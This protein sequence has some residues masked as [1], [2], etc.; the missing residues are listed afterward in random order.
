MFLSTFLN[1]TI[2]K[3]IAL[4]VAMTFVWPYL[5]W[6]FE[7]G[8]YPVGPMAVLYNQ[9]RV[10]IPKEMGLVQAAY[11]GDRQLV[12]LVQDLHCNLEVQNNIA[13]II[14]TLTKKHGLNMIAVEGASQA[15]N[16]AQLKTFP[17]ARVKRVVGQYFLK[18]GK[19]SGAEYYAATA[20]HP[21]TLQGIEKAELYTA[22]RDAVNAFLND[23]SQGYVYDL[24]ELFKELKPSIYTPELLG[25]DKQKQDNREGKV[26]M[27]K[28]AVGVWN[29]GKQLGV[30][31]GAYPNVA[32][33]V[34]KKAALF[35]EVSPDTLYEELES[36][37]REI[38]EHLY[39]SAAQRK[40]DVL[41][42]RLDIME[43]MLNI[44]V[45]P[46]ELKAFRE[47]SGDFKVAEFLHFIEA[48]DASGELRLDAEVYDLDKYLEKVKHFYELADARSTVFVENTLKHMSE[49]KTNI[50]VMVSG[51]FHNDGV[52][53]ALKSRK[54]SYLSVQPAITHEDLV[55]PYYSLLRN[56][57]NP[58]EKLLAENQNI[59]A[60]ASA[61]P[62]AIQTEKPL[63]PGEWA[64][65]PEAVKTF[66]KVMDLVLK[67]G[68]L[69]DAAQASTKVSDV[70]AAFE[71]MVRNAGM[72]SQIQPL[73]EQVQ[74]NEATQTM[75]VPMSLGGTQALSLVIRPEGQGVA[76]DRSLA[77]VSLDG[78]IEAV[79]VEN[80]VLAGMEKNILGVHKVGG[81]LVGA[82]L[83]LQSPVA[84]LVATGSTVMLAPGGWRSYLSQLKSGFSGLEKPLQG[85]MGLRSTE[86]QM[87]RGAIDVTT[88]GTIAGLGVAGVGVFMAL[89]AGVA[90]LPA[91]IGGVVMAA[92]LY[93]LAAWRGNK[94]VS[95]QWIGIASA[96]G[97]AL[98]ALGIG[99]ALTG[100]GLVALFIIPLGITLPIGASLNAADVIT[101]EYRSS[102]AMM[103][104][105][106]EGLLGIA[107]LAQVAS[108]FGEKYVWWSIF[109][110]LAGIL[111]AVIGLFGSTSARDLSTARL[112][113]RVWVRYQTAVK[114]L[115]QASGFKTWQDIAERELKA[116][117][118]WDA[119]DNSKNRAAVKKITAVF[120]A[121][122]PVQ[123][124]SLA[125][126]SF[127]EAKALL[128]QV[129]NAQKAAEEKAEEQKVLELGTWQAKRETALKAAGQTD[130]L[131]TN[132]REQL[133]DQEQARRKA[134]DE[135][136]A[137][138]VY[139]NPKMPLNLKD[140]TGAKAKLADP[141]TQAVYTGYRDKDQAI[142][143]MQETG[144]Y[145]H[146]YLQADQ[147]AQGRYA[148]KGWIPADRIPRAV[149][150]Q[151]A[152]ETMLP[153][154]AVVP[155][156]VQN[157]EQAKAVLS[158]AATR[159][160]Y[161]TAAE[162][163]A[164]IQ[165]MTR[166]QTGKELYVIG[167]PDADGLVQTVERFIAPTE[168][169]APGGR[170]F[171]RGYSEIAPLVGIT[172]G[173]FAGAGAFYVLTAWAGLTGLSV[174]G[175]VLGVAL[176]A[177]VLSAWLISRKD[178]TAKESAP[179]G[180]RK[181][182]RQFWLSNSLGISELRAMEAFIRS[183]LH[184]GTRLV[185]TLMLVVTLVPMGA[186][187]YMQWNRAAEWD[188][189][190]AAQSIGHIKELAANKDIRGLL[191]VRDEA[192]ARLAGTRTA[193]AEA[194]RLGWQRLLNRSEKSLEQL[195]REHA[196]DRMAVME[197][198]LAI[199]RN[200][201]DANQAYRP[202]GYATWHWSASLKSLEQ[203]AQTTRREGPLAIEL[204]QL[205]TE[206]RVQTDTLNA[207]KTDLEAF[208][209]TSP[210][211]FD[212]TNQTIAT[213]AA[214]E[215]KTLE[216]E[217]AVEK[218]LYE[219][220]NQGL[221][222]RVDARLREQ[223]SDFGNQSQ[224]HD[225]LAAFNQSQVQP[226]LLYATQVRDSL[227]ERYD[228]YE[229]ASHHVGYSGYSDNA[230]EDERQQGLRNSYEADGEAAGVKA[231]MAL[232]K[233]NA[234]W[235]KLGDTGV[236]GAE[237]IKIPNLLRQSMKGESTL[238]TPI[239][240][241]GKLQLRPNE[242]LMVDNEQVSLKAVKDFAPL[243]DA[244]RELAVS[245]NTKTQSQQQWLQS[246]IE[247]DIQK[248]ILEVVAD[249][250][251]AHPFRAQTGILSGVVSGSLAALQGVALFMLGTTSP[252]L[253]IPAIVLGVFFGGYLT[254]S[255]VNFVRVGRA[256]RDVMSDVLRESEPTLSQSELT[257]RA[258]TEAIAW[259]DGRMNDVAMKKLEATHPWA[260]AQVLFHES[261][262]TELGGLLAMLPGVRVLMTRLNISAQDGRTSEAEQVGN[263]SAVVPNVVP[264]V[265]GKGQEAKA[266]GQ[267][268]AS[269]RMDLTY[270]KQARSLLTSPKVSAVSA[271][272]DDRTLAI[273]L[274][275]ELGIY[276]NMDIIALDAQNR[277]YVVETLPATLIKQLKTN[278]SSED[279]LAL[280]TGEN[281]PA[282][283]Y[284]AKV[285]ALHRVRLDFSSLDAARVLLANPKTK[286]ISVPFADRM[287]AIALMQATG[288]FSHLFLRDE[289]GREIQYTLSE[290]IP[291]IKVEQTLEEQQTMRWGNL[292]ITN[293]LSQEAA[294]DSEKIP[295]HISGA[296]NRSPFDGAIIGA[297]T[298]LGSIDPQAAGMLYSDKSN[299][300]QKS[301]A[302]QILYRPLNLQD[303][304]TAK[305]VLANPETQF[306]YSSYRNLD[307]VVRLMQETGQYRHLA[308][309]ADQDAQGRY[310]IKGWIPA[311][312]I[313]RPET[314]SGVVV[315]ET[316][317][318]EVQ[319]L[320]VTDEKGA[321]DLLGR[322]GTRAVYVEGNQKDSAMALMRKLQLAKELFVLSA[323]DA[324]G[325]VTTQ[326]RIL[327]SDILQSKPSGRG[328]ERGMVDVK[329]LGTVAA[330]GVVVVGVLLAIN[331]GVALA[332]A[333]VAGV[334]VL[335][336]VYGVARWNLG[337][338]V[339][340]KR[341]GVA[342][343]VG[344][345]LVT[346][347]IAV[348][349][350]VAAAGSTLVVIPLILIGI[351]YPLGVFIN[352]GD[353][354]TPDLRSG[355][356][357]FVAFW[358]WI[359]AVA[360]IG[361]AVD[362]MGLGHVSWVVFGG[363]FGIFALLIG[364]A[365]SSS[366]TLSTLQLSE[367]IWVRFQTSVRE[368]GKADSWH[369]WRELAERELKAANMWDKTS[370]W[371]SRETLSRLEDVYRA[372]SYDQQKQLVGM[373]AK[374]AK[375]VLAKAVSES[376]P[377]SFGSRN[378]RGVS[379]IAPMVS[380]SAGVIA[381]VV[382]WLLAPALLG[383]TGVA[384]LGVAAGVALGMGG[385]ALWLINRAL[386]NEVAPQSI[387]RLNTTVELP[388]KDR[389]IQLL[390][391]EVSLGGFLNNDG[392]FL[393]NQMSLTDAEASQALLIIRLTYETIKKTYPTL[394]QV[395]PD[396]IKEL[397]VLELEGADP[398]VVE[399]AI[400]Q[401]II[402]ERYGR[403]SETTIANIRR[404]GS[405]THL[406]AQ[407]ITR[408][409]TSALR[410]F[411]DVAPMV[412]LGLGVLAGV[413]AF[414][415]LP[416]LLGLSGA[417][418]L[419]IAAVVALVVGGSAL[420]YLSR[421]VAV[422]RTVSVVEGEAVNK[423]LR[424]E[425]QEQVTHELNRLR[426][427]LPEGV[428]EPVRGLRFLPMRLLQSGLQA[429]LF[430]NDRQTSAS[431][432]GAVK[433]LAAVVLVGV[434]LLAGAVTALATTGTTVR[435]ADDSVRLEAMKK[436]LVVPDADAAK[437]YGVKGLRFRG[438]SEQGGLI[439]RLFKGALLGMYS[440]GDKTSNDQGVWATVYVP[441]VLL[442]TVSQPMP[443]A[444]GT[445]RASMARLN[446]QV[447][448]FLFGVIAGQQANNYYS[449]LRKDVDYSAEAVV[450]EKTVDTLQGGQTSD[451]WLAGKHEKVGIESASVVALA[452]AYLQEAQAVQK[453]SGENAKSLAR[454]ALAQ[455]LAKGAE[456]SLSALLQVVESLPGEQAN[457]Y[458]ALALEAEK[459]EKAKRDIVVQKLMQTLIAEDTPGN[460]L[461]GVEAHVMQ[462]GQTVYVMGMPQT[463]QALLKQVTEQKDALGNQAGLQGL[464]DRL[465]TLEAALKQLAQTPAGQMLAL[466]G[467]LGAALVGE[468]ARQTRTWGSQLLTLGEDLTRVNHAVA[469]GK[470]ST[471]TVDGI[472][473]AQT[474]VYE[475]NA[476]M[477]KEVTV[478][479]VME[480]K[481]PKEMQA[482]VYAG[483]REA[484]VRAPKAGVLG[485]VAGSV[486]RVLNTTSAQRWALQSD[487]LGYLQRG[488]ATLNESTLQRLLQDEGS[489]VAQAFLRYAEK[490]SSRTREQ[491]FVKSM[492]RALK[493]EAKQVE[494]L[495]KAGQVTEAMQAQ[496]RFETS[497]VAFSELAGTLKV[498]NAQ[499]L[500]SWE[501]VQGKAGKTIYVPNAL[502]VTGGKGAFGAYVD[503]L[504]KL[505]T[506]VD[507]EQLEKH[508]RRM[509]RSAAQAA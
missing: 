403:S 327:A 324:E 115:G 482:K 34:T 269:S 47:H 379:E 484:V 40:L 246:Q 397:M 319:A 149:A 275:H 137:A 104:G 245:V 37:D 265:K 170:G 111:A 256:V 392:A 412:G 30:N 236:L 258:N 271:A 58:L 67:S 155:L 19:M 228:N 299:A 181:G 395:R 6:A 124:Q 335:A 175:S 356:V 257:R 371:G 243:Y 349:A 194:E 161:V 454:K 430:A 251:V 86:R 220:V 345:V 88:L 216:A 455:E 162:K 209:A 82:N 54:I 148:M 145:H 473:L 73:W 215:L 354:V 336:L 222:Q 24:R 122:E 74:V 411:S 42:R 351:T 172:A 213:T 195:K 300:S 458:R 317:G 485:T 373:S 422:T 489:P 202:G 230:A 135:G 303:I 41:E 475:V 116:A 50:G 270:L 255:A 143:L 167:T 362:R 504:S 219:T 357:M 83:F 13:K 441:D 423:A 44:S 212:G 462:T 506:K 156:V 393:K 94:I 471:V 439:Q 33:Y 481:L 284:I 192:R 187:G 408:Q 160:V 18:Q 488:A 468:S 176:L 424:T 164:A 103:V 62:Q 360:G 177:G 264:L 201:L 320:N 279:R 159:V 11:Q 221:R 400:T 440:E 22:S 442:E 427:V 431:M 381:G 27:L 66:A 91:I 186:Y 45:K 446:Y 383:L 254:L 321:A 390:Q 274:M 459:L 154:R 17:N 260:A 249:S 3:T 118:L 318:R 313:P 492:L 70:K 304:E 128:A 472:D 361:W 467:N 53:A 466:E 490:P 444:D 163:N 81:A 232:G 263:T 43:R 101:P 306:V 374:Q 130:V 476:P 95:D 291:N 185:G 329:T 298:R 496:A 435:V 438:L 35:G 297:E 14:G 188:R 494:A 85:L 410:G 363:F 277:E 12:V 288:H 197:A 71:A 92:I 500:G 15:V 380:I 90:M 456:P 365:G 248:Q 366:Q 120:E 445:F 2:V 235:A 207:Y 398:K 224:R 273:Q 413:A 405:G 206:V 178:S 151:G 402:D 218:A 240:A 93:G 334:L 196:Y 418:A 420:G 452:Q 127:K 499:V 138:E 89:N 344:L 28:Y 470:V 419:G 8:S 391:S 493:V 168:T 259:S 330:V 283:R 429:V 377:R 65:Q 280:R 189:S 227:K 129:A 509:F 76:I 368:L 415:A 180:A 266:T 333:I 308:L 193:M 126:M 372:L 388:L 231:K 507:T 244:I 48:H 217:T 384:A 436:L 110:G 171:E 347:G 239:Y 96:S 425:T 4:V 376:A 447:K 165:L 315:Q 477:G 100:W 364:I 98:I 386:P 166:I 1:K 242:T 56:R 480:A 314:T 301:T 426:E 505:A 407:G 102:Y 125:E 448:A 417:A 119:Q 449:G 136:E 382:L 205:Y 367:R 292:P 59:L 340:S 106:W 483:E 378:Q 199:N 49:A 153:D 133:F 287:K 174:V 323:P 508:R 406:K 114:Q 443:A 84:A 10:T 179:A 61:F 272:W 140:L 346:L 302:Y 294:N 250:T 141:Q 358:E 312:R 51:G 203:E 184:N 29:Q 26:P 457:V 337:Q 241:D 39:T 342:N 142:Q 144:Y 191:R 394:Q 21:V 132:Q 461:R 433:G 69:G 99:A 105:F 387:R 497:M 478:A 234:H 278:L 121:L 80:T 210:N 5:T 474:Q 416:V 157:S 339:Y 32:R 370:V 464:V 328:S 432:Q 307:A 52:L 63:E 479:A 7:A 421:T 341:Q 226:L 152:A 502:L 75:I 113:V 290:E 16:L 463:Y 268:A 282:K 57:K 229:N 261:F 79:L 487:P 322:N 293:A 348:A 87:Q 211:W 350:T 262:K 289:K 401:I 404:V 343:A 55:N 223:R 117:Q 399:R 78:K 465:T 208:R 107:A 134:L 9:S 310:A 182:N 491:A 150:G 296:K 200:T 139:K 276:K 325:I 486:A 503:M 460:A 158:N 38:R 252:A 311:D 225:K 428:N 309:Q 36:L 72:N 204:N 332:P 285:M 385:L 131:T 295:L 267:K 469:T 46:E 498:L 169:K 369:L 281:T 97:L 253:V 60:L 453:Q 396:Y 123:R 23:E 414:F 247:Q 352:A 146:L 108:L 389:L 64:Q 112:S 77:H 375:Q 316:V 437:E 305:A 190:A 434:S 109:L 495:E 353:V 450:A 68:A 355:Y 238:S 25:L 214:D 409:G 331:A 359:L 20:E 198:E 501:T 237:N 451:E 147:D 326:E 183:W 338:T 31:V 286:A 173:V 233:L